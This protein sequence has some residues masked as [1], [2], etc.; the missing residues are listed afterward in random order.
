MTRTLERAG[1]QADL[2]A[3]EALL[4]QR[5]PDEDPVGWMQFQARAESIRQQLEALDEELDTA[6]AV[7][8]FFGGLP[9]V[10]SRGIQAEFGGKV[11]ERFQDAVSTELAAT[12]G[13]VG[14]RGP[15]P[16]WAR[17]QLLITGVARGSI[18]FVLEEAEPEGQLVDSPL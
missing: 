13:T 16:L 10:G 18:G 15:I 12:Q 3:V 9:V 14:T 11:L 17:D 1:L 2:A 6:A 5:T 4:G 7:A 8:L